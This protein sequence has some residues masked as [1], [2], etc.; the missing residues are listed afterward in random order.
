[1][2]EIVPLTDCCF[3]RFRVQSVGLIESLVSSSNAIS[4]S[5]MSYS[6]TGTATTPVVSQISSATIVV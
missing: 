4:P 1:M 6:H 5:P 2:F 3:G